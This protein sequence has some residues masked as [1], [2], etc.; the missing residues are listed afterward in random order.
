LFLEK[1]PPGIVIGPEGLS[2]ED[3]GVLRESER[4]AREDELFY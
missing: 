4:S 2:D 3:R 1:V